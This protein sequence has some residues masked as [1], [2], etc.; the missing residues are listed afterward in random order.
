M[1]ADLFHYGHSEYLRK[2]SE[3]KNDGDKLYVGIH[4]DETVQSY[5]R[6]PV[7]TMD[8]RIKVISSCK[9]IDKVIPD[10]PMYI[11]KEYIDLYKIDLFFIPDNRISEDITVI[12]N[13]VPISVNPAKIPHEMG[14]VKKIPYTHEIST[15]DII[16]RIKNRT[17]L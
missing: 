15:T 1:V 4:N 16:K 14:I 9:Y 3:F 11:T 10:A 13:G 5:K 7:L 17:D 8:E 6:L 12:N 2:I